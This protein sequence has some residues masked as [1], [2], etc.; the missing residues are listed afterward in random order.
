MKI[1]TACC[2]VPD[3]H[4]AG[5]GI[6]REIMD[7]GHVTAPT[8][9]FAFCSAATDAPAFVRGLRSVVGDT[10]P[11]VGGS[12]IGI[13]TNTHLTYEKCCAGA[14]FIEEQT[15]RFRIAAVGGLDHDET[16]A[17][18]E[19]ARRL[20]PAGDEQLLFVFWDSIRKPAANRLP[21]VLNASAPL[22]KGIS[23]VVGSAVPVFGAGLLAD[24]HFGPTVQFTGRG[25]ERQY[26]VGVL[27]RG[28]ETPFFRITH[29]CTP[30]D[31]VYHRIT[32][33]R[34]E[35]IHEIDAKP[36]ATVIDALYGGRHWRT[37]SPVSLLAIGVNQSKKYGPTD[38]KSFVIRLITGVLPGDAI[39]L[40]EPDLNSGDEF[41]FMLRDSQKM[42]ASARRNAEDLMRDIERRGRRPLLGV[43]I[44]CAGRTAGYAG[45]LQEEAAEIQRVFN[46]HSCPLFG[47]FTG[48]EVAP[49]GS[50][51]RGL[52][53]SGVLICF[54]GE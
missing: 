26:A 8:T 22:L 54:T 40:F 29:G 41:L 9:V 15:P 4:A 24:H 1:D 49:F 14:L 52:D 30:L 23:D 36:A 50:C 28:P 32:R 43:Y 48:V 33:M 46:H 21:P 45:M 53:W 47:F 25:I 5:S 17:G 27:F 7:R 35:V 19:L 51:S 37:Q 12:A 6:A 34:G 38:E 10:V 20:V 2:S 13:I 42:I 39:G 44:D 18:R 11:I 3:S 16:A 31:G